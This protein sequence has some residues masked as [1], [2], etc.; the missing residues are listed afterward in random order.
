MKI[1]THI[2]RVLLGLVFAVFGLNGFLNFIPQGPMPTGF[3][4]Q[5]V[6]ALMGSHYMLPICI[7]ELAAGLLFLINRYVAVAVTLT[8][9]VIV[10]ILLYHAF[11]DSLLAHMVPAIVVTVLWGIVFCSVR[12]AFAPI[13]QAKVTKN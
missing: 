6:G 11:M 7:I 3:A 4:G 2:A 9:P 12:S 1:I 13:F 10:N 5:F 8:G